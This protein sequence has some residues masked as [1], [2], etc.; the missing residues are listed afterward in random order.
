MA[1]PRQSALHRTWVTSVME[2]LT[3]SLLSTTTLT[4]FA[5]F[6]RRTWTSGVI[7]ADR[8]RGRARG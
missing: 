8:R 7:G 1:C 3:Q 6:T 2:A 4:G 5:T